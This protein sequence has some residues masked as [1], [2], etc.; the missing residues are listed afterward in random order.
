M[1][2]KTNLKNYVR[3][4]S[5][6]EYMPSPESQHYPFRHQDSLI[7]S[8]VDGTDGRRTMREVLAELG[9]DVRSHKTVT[10]IRVQTST[11]LCPYLRAV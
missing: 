5:D 9:A 2:A 4:A 3:T 1:R 10:D 8:V 7:R 6:L 11:S